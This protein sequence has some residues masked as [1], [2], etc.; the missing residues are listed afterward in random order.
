MNTSISKYFLAIK[1]NAFEQFLQTSPIVRIHHKHYHNELCSAYSF[2][3][4]KTGQRHQ[5][6][7]TSQKGRQLE[8]LYGHRELIKS[9]LAHYRTLWNSNFVQPCPELNL[10]KIKKSRFSFIAKEMFD[11]LIP[12]SN[13]R[14]IERPNPY[15]GT[16]FRSKSERE[17]AELLDE[18]GIDY[19]YEPLMRFNDIDM[20]PDFVCYIPEIGVGFIIEHFGMIDNVNYIETSIRKFRTYTSLGLIPGIDILF[21]YEKNNAPPTA[22]Y[23]RNSINCI[24]DNICAP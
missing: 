7:S 13:P 23:F 4:R 12:N 14:P 24:L 11:N 1:I 20:Y 9:K 16:I 21:T 5:Y 10:E 6:L 8:L 17:I 15:N 22:A 19:K 2:T 18:I 3:E